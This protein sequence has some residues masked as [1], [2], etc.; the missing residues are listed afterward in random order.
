MG[1]KI[2]TQPS[3]TQQQFKE[4]TNINNIMSR[5]KTTGLVPQTQRRP[6]F[7]D[8][9]AL[10][11]QQMMNSISDVEQN[12][13]SLPSRIRGRFKNDPYQLLRF[14]EDPANIEEAIKLKLLAPPPTTYEEAYELAAQAEEEKLIKEQR[15]AE[16]AAKALRMKEIAETLTA[17][18]KADPEAQP[19]FR[20]QTP[21]EGG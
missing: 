4:E 8:F 11:F 15:A 5:Y 12:F 20:K 3:R 21:P 9:M 16:A 10:D 6:I 19:A 2:F 1:K 13:A 7:G 18:Q 14:V 17:M